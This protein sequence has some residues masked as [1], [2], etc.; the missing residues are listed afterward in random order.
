MQRHQGHFIAIAC[1]IEI[2]YQRDML[3]IGFQRIKP[4]H[5]ADELLEVIKPAGGLGTLVFA[6]HRRVA[7]FI[8]DDLGQLVM[9]HRVGLRPPALDI[10]QENLQGGARLAAYLVGLDHQARHLAHRDTRRARRCGDL[11]HA[12]LA[13]PALG[14]VHDPLECQIVLGRAHKAHI[15]VGITHFRAFKEARTANDLVGQAQHDE[16]VFKRAHLPGRTHQNGDIIVLVAGADKGLDLVGD[17]TRFR[18]PVPQAAHLYLLAGIILGPQRLAKTRAVGPDEAGGRAENMPRRAV[19]AF[20][21]DHGGAGKIGFEAQ[22]VVHF[23]AAP[24]IDGLVVIAHTAHIARPARQEAQPEILADIGVLI[25]VHQKIAEAPVIKRQHIGIFGEDRQIVQ[26]EIAEIAGIEDFQPLLVEPVEHISLAVRER[27][28]VLLAQLFR[29]YAPVLPAIDEAGQMARR[30]AL[31]VYPLGLEDLLDQ[32]QLVIGI[33]DGEGG[34]QPHQLGMPAQNLR[35]DGVEGAKPGQPLHCLTDNGADTLLHLAGGLVGEGHREDF[36]RIGPACGKDMSKPGGQD[37]R[38]AGACPREHENRPVSRL[39]S[40]ALL[41]V[42][43][44][45]I[46]RQAGLSASGRAGRRLLG[47]GDRI[48]GG[49]DAEQSIRT[50]AN[51]TSTPWGN[52]Q[53]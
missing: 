39:H 20:Q 35:G 21:T 15:G 7:A 26:Q 11:L 8:E 22:N 34:F 4:A 5:G 32:A 9:A 43:S 3:Q 51:K 30:P 1:L 40:G 12:G 44:L 47:Q 27:P 31:V 10:A 18:I 38:L 48:H 53:G 52:R 17:K 45:Q 28:A 49:L 36:P 6:P 29:A 14:D 46:T 25:L 2:R 16:A 13:N 50:G 24:A 42:Q 37:A 19:I 33:Q 23:R 41:C